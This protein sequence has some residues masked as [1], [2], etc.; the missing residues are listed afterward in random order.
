MDALA[1][2]NPAGFSHLCSH[3]SMYNKPMSPGVENFIRKTLIEDVKLRNAN[4]NYTLWDIPGMGGQLGKV[5]PFDIY[6]QHV[7]IDEAEMRSDGKKLT[8]GVFRY[9]INA[10]GVRRRE[11][12]RRLYDYAT[13]N[14]ALACGAILGGAFL[15]HSRRRFTFLQRRPALSILLSLGIVAAT[16]PVVRS[17]F[18]IFAVG[19]A[20]AERQHSKALRATPCYD[21]LSDI[22]EFT[23]DQL[24]DLKTAKLPEPKPGMPPI[25][26]EQ[27]KAFKAAMDMQSLI[28]GRDLTTIRSILKEMLQKNNLLNWKPSEKVSKKEA[29]EETRIKSTQE[30]V[31][32]LISNR[33]V[34]EKLLCEV[35]RG[36][37][38]DPDGYKHPEDYPVFNVDRMNA[39][40]RPPAVKDVENK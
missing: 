7:L 6:G 33:Q 25:S 38:R 34:P 37:R 24:K 28:L 27:K 2:S 20:I 23:E 29:E 19:I 26:D 9:L 1:A 31:A 17:L 32:F 15:Y 36:V 13:M 35:H 11:G 21:C 5:L 39:K 10:A 14:F 4:T 18:K 22:Y 12:G 8:H 30:E 16:V 3:I 40:R